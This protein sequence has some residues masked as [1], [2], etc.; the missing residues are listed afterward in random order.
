V[1][2]YKWKHDRYFFPHQSR[3]NVAHS[4][5]MLQNDAAWIGYG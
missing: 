4:D 2:P 5:V 3:Y 1:P